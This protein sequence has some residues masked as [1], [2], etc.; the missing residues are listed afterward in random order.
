MDNRAPLLGGARYLDNAWVLPGGPNAPRCTGPVEPTDPPRSRVYRAILSIIVLAIG[1]FLT[2]LAVGDYTP[3]SQSA[4]FNSVNSA[5]DLSASGGPNYN[6]VFV[7]VGPIMSIVGAYLVGAYHVARRRFE[8]LM[9]SRSKAEFL[10]NL[11]EVEDLL[12][13]LLPADELRYEQKKSELRIR[14]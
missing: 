13:D 2:M 6:L 9:L 3:I 8:H 14:R 7:I 5:T 11:P 10:R 1:I 12:W 4:P